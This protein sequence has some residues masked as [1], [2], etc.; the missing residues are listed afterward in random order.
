MV[1]C[2]VSCLMRSNYRGCIGTGFGIRG[3]LEVGLGDV[4]GA[5]QLFQMSIGTDLTQR[6]LSGEDQH[7]LGAM[8]PALLDPA[9]LQILA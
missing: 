3:L 1:N 8:K 7:S 9:S 4:L 2:M 5:A 6:T